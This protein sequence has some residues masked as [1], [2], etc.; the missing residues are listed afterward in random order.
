MTAPLRPFPLADREARVARIMAAFRGAGAETIA[1]EALQPAEMLLDL[2]GEDIRARAYVVREGFRERMLRPDFTVPVVRHHIAAGR[3]SAR[4]AYQGPVWRRPSE[5]SDRPAESWQAGIEILGSE[6][7]AAADAEVFSLVHT[8]LRDAPI[9]VATGDLALL[10]AAIGALSGPE[11]RRQ[12]LL[13]HIWRPERFQRLLGQFASPATAK[14]ALLDRVDAE[15]GAAVLGAS[16]KHVGLRSAEEILSRVGTL[17]QDAT[18][19]PVPETEIAVIR[20]VLALSGS[21]PE[22]ARDVE[23]LANDVPA[24]SPAAQGFSARLSAL[25]AFG[26]DLE[27][28]SF[29]GS[30]GRTTLEYYDGFVFGVLGRDRDDLPLIASGGRYDALTEALGT[31]LPAIGAVVRPEAWLALEAGR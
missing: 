6:D 16:G 18:L 20:R 24:L 22:V 12:A 28:L 31:D 19:P 15:G 1:L 10:R 14:R 30:F 8:L 9:T 3:A 7:R 25:D 5:G 23:R 17:T 11:T 29:E 26:I 4:Y 27:T 21:L 2:Y 13:R